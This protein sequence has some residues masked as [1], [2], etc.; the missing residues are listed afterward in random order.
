V[1][2]FETALSLLNYMGAWSAS[3]DWD[4]RRMPDSAHQTTVPFQTFATSDGWLVVACAKEDMWRHFCGAIGR[5]DLADDERFSVFRARDVN[6]GELLAILRESL[7]ERTVAEWVG[8][9]REAKVP[10]APVNDLA[11]ALADEQATA[12]G[13]V[14]QYE[15]PVLGDVRPIASPFG[16]D[17]EIHRGPLL[18][19]HTHELLEGVYGY[20]AER[21]DALAKAGAFG[22][23]TGEEV[24]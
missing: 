16:G 7:A 2:L 17:G 14:V 5:S 9:F 22:S 11:G 4:P 19:E 12:R 15:H 13:A 10:A 24:T 18:G 21:I 20:K 3:R 8:A 23:R 6:R 1:S